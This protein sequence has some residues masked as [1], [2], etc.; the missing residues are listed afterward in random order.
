[1]AY[2]APIVAA[3]TELKCPA[4]IGIG[5]I[6]F[7]LALFQLTHQGKMAEHTKVTFFD[8]TAISL[9]ERVFSPSS[10]RG[11]HNREDKHIVPDALTL[12]HPDVL[13]SS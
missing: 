13:S 4:D 2:H 7:S 3:L 8:R 9:N 11:M 5:E 6:H 12:S 10:T 1:V